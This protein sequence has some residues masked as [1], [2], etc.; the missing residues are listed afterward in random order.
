MTSIISDLF[1]KIYISP[2]DRIRW[3][4]FLLPVCWM[5]LICMIVISDQISNR[6]GI[7]ERFSFVCLVA[8]AV[9]VFVIFYKTVS[10]RTGGVQEI[11]FIPFY[12]LYEA[13]KRPELYRQMLMNV[14]LF[15][16]LGLVVPFG[17]SW[18]LVRK[19][20]MTVSVYDRSSSLVVVKYSVLF[21]LCLSLMIELCQGF[22]GLGRAETDDVIMN[23]LGALIG[24]VCYLAVVL[25][26]VLTWHDIARIIAG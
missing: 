22:F 20:M 24:I 15:E 1:H 14:F 7:I 5:V 25:F 16:P 4:M 10:G 18:L 6:P 21:C 11:I 2:L 3:I 9:I 8:S 12:T 26:I 23:L 13:Q 19:K 17:L